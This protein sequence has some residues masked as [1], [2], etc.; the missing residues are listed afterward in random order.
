MQLHARLFVRPAESRVDGGAW[1][2]IAVLQI[3]YVARR[4]HSRLPSYDYIS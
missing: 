3:C 1:R 2:V 4:E